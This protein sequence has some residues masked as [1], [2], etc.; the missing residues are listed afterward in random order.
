MKGGLKD[1]SGKRFW[2]DSAN[3]K[4]LLIEY[5]MVIVLMAMFLML[6]LSTPAFLTTRNIINL[7]RQISVNAILAMG[8]TFVII[9]GGI[10]LSVGSVLAVGGVISASIVASGAVPVWIAVI[11]GIA[12]GGLLGLINGLVVSRLKV[13]PFVI[14]L[15]MMTI[16]RGIA[17]VYTDGRPIVGLPDRFRVIGRDSIGF[18]PVPVIIMILVIVFCWFL[19]QHTLFGR[20]VF[21]IGGNREAAKVSGINIKRMLTLVYTF[22][23]L[24]AGLA[25]VVLASRINSGQPQAG[26]T[27]ELDAIAAVVIGGTS[28]A[29]GVGSITGTFIGA[30]IM[31]MINNGLNLL[32][33]SAYYQMIIQGIIIVLA[34]T[35]DVMTSKDR[36]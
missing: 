24:I 7:S 18:I 34:V 11:S 35:M 8:M 3:W 13:A 17:Y 31:G 2:S 33:V 22:N 1:P 28:L 16:A 6:T 12:V 23:G 4:D 19:L 32:R 30:V 21:Y 26:L 5:R 14:T 36:E 20:Y 27:Y 10:D 25:G 29:G 15:A 9:T